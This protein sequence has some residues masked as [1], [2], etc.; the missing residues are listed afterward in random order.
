MVVVSSAV[1]GTLGGAQ[2]MAAVFAGS[3]LLVAVP[4]AGVHFLQVRRERMG[5]AYE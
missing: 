3:S 4:L 2:M 1:A 5:G